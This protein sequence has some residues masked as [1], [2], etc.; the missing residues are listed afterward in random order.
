MPGDVADF[1]YLLTLPGDDVVLLRG[2]NSAA[3]FWRESSAWARELG[4]SIG[5][6]QH[7]A[8]IELATR[9]LTDHEATRVKVLPRKSRSGENK[10]SLPK[11]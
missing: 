4:M 8:A 2:A 3:A 7:T 6:D 1:I 10:E 11:N 5:D 9:I